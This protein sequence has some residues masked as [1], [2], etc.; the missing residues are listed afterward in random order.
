ME[1]MVDRLTIKAKT[2]LAFGVMIVLLCV[3]GITGLDRLRTINARAADIRDHW[4]PSTGL[5]GQVLSAIQEIR[6]TEARYALA[7]D[8]G[9]RQQIKR[10]MAAASQT[11]DRLRAEY[12]HLIHRGTAD[13]R[14]MLDFDR[15][16]A[17]HLA[18]VDRDIGP[19]GEPENLFGDEEN[20][21]YAAAFDAS[22]SDL[23]RNL[24]EGRLA[25]SVGASVYGPT[26]RFLLSVLCVA[27]AIGLILAA[28]IVA[29]VS[30]PIR[31]LTDA[32]RRIADQRLDTAIPGLRRSDEL[33]GMAAAVQVFKTAMLERDRLST[34]QEREHAS[35]ERKAEHTEALLRAFELQAGRM[36]GLLA[37][38]SA[39][40][41]AMAGRMKSAAQ[42]TDGQAGEVA[43]AA[44]TAGSGVQAVAAAAEQLTAS[45]AEISR[46]IEISSALTRRAVEKARRTDETVG[47]LASAADDI[48]RVVQLISQIAGQTNLLALNA[49]IEAARAGDAGKGFAVVASEVKNLAAQTT[50]ATGEITS[51]VGAIQA[52]S[53]N[54][55]ASI[56]EIARTIEDLGDVAAAVATAV[57]Q[58]GAATREIAQNAQ[59]TA[60]ATG[61][62][63]SKICDV[64]VSANDTGAAATAVLV[65]ASGLSRQA[66]DLSDEVALFL[67]NVRA[68]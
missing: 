27:V 10:E 58:Q 18:A 65:S 49:T 41:E 32:M 8:D 64:S 56:S 11:L 53:R 61:V 46:Q 13:A 31:R 23:D 29:N 55:V 52:A 12:G 45:V 2:L 38:A 21:S 33:G 35:R 19:G 4:L 63:A 39:E 20:R 17:S 16:W 62:V 48:G 57:D 14:L 43:S 30:H 51:Q 40:L 54:A 24:R 1:P 68:A 36:T 37:D 44:A 25:A 34:E 6:L 15:A 7:L 26:K 47:D 59:T 3:L 42:E 5:Q 22:R 66:H 67:Q 28:A 50:T 9:D 60:G